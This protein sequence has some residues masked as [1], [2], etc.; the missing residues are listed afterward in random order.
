LENVEER[1]EAALQAAGA[2]LL[3]LRRMGARQLE[4]RYRFMEERF[5]TV[6]D[7]ITLQV[8]DSGICLGHGEERGD[9]LLTL[10]SLPSVIKEAIETGVL[11]ITR[12]FA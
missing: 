6:C 7:A 1:A 9:E 12:R 11:V 4:V 2:R 5:V 8:Y 3:A 10:E